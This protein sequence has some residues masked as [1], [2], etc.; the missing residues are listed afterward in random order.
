VL[1]IG[2]QRFGAFGG[3]GLEAGEEDVFLRVVA[4][5]G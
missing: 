1:A 4:L 5:L 3:A 2:R